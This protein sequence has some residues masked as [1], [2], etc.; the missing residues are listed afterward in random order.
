MIGAVIIGL[1][2]YL[3]PIVEQHEWEIDYAL[4]APPVSVMFFFFLVVAI[5]TLLFKFPR[6]LALDSNELLLIYA[7]T[8]V[9][10]PLSSFGLVQFLIPNMVGPIHFATKENMWREDFWHYI[11]NWFGPRDLRIIDTSFSVR[12]ESP[13]DLTP[14]PPSLQGKGEG[15]PLSS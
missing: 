5:N 4:P 7:M 6:P 8:M 10:V 13:S 3:C 11:P 15:T 12:T 9:G 2:S 1:I 14:R